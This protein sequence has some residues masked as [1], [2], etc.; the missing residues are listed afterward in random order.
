MVNLLGEL[1]GG[2][3]HDAVHRFLR[4][5]QAVQAVDYR[6]EVCG[7]LAGAGLGY[8]DEVAPFEHH[9]YG[10][11]LNGG[12]LVETHRVECVKYVVAEV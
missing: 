10:L 4:F 6:E 5:G 2:S 3:H 12:A 1:A 9:G 11:L 7:G 8:G